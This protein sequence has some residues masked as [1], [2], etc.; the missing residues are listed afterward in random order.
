MRGFKSFGLNTSLA[1]EPGISIIVGPNG[2]GKSNIVDAVS[3]VLGEQSP[4]SLRG[5]SMQD[6]IFKSK[7]EEFAIA[8]VSLL[9]N[10]EDKTLPIE[11]SEVKLTRRAYLKGGSE[12]FINSSPARLTDIQDL[13][14][15]G[16]LGKGLYT[17]VNQGQINDIVL[18][19]PLERK[20]II[21][22]VIGISRHKIR[23]DKSKD[24]LN[25]VEQDINRIN[26]LLHEIKI[27]MDPLEVEAK[28]SK[29]LERILNELKNEEISLFIASINKLNNQ[30]DEENIKIER[31]NIEIKQINENIN[32]L[33]NQKDEFEKKIN[34]KNSLVFSIEENLNKF[35]SMVNELISF[36]SIV[37]NQKTSMETI[38]NMIKFSLSNLEMDRINILTNGNEE[39]KNIK[40]KSRNDFIKDEN[41]RNVVKEKIE[42]CLKNIDFIILNLDK[43]LVPVFAVEAKS[44]MKN[45]KLNII[46]IGDSISNFYNNIGNKKDKSSSD[47]LIATKKSLK[48]KSKKLERIKEI[49]SSVLK[50]VST[51]EMVL[52]KLIGESTS[53]KEK[54][55]IKLKEEKDKY[56]EE[57]N[58]LEKYFAELNKLN[59]RK[60]FLENDIY[61]GNLK[62]DQIKEKVKDLTIKIFDDYN[63]PLDFIIKNFKP[64][65]DINKT[66]LKVKELKN[67]LKKYKNVNPNAY[68]EYE[69]IK[70]RFDFLNGQ[71]ID[72]VDSK[73]ELEEIIEEL[74]K[75][76]KEH[77]NQKFQE[78]NEN[79]KFYFKILFP[80]GE[81][82]LVIKD[83]ENSLEDDFGVDIKVDIGNNKSVSLHLLS[84]GEKT[85]VSIAFLFSIFSSNP[86]PFYVFDEIDASLDDANIDRLLN[87]IKIFSQ[88]RQL[89]MVTHQKR[90]MEIADVI[91]GFSMQSNGITKIV[92]QKIKGNVCSN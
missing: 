66:E 78:I 17:I 28:K 50:N 52:S 2:S 15:E 6:V 87:L 11:F 68:L 9:F 41:F 55:N 32:T 16:G 36:K 18:F 39:N 63:M 72:L 31:N 37:N 22:E 69:R 24:R 43:W 73:K 86:S 49:I 62:K 74:D 61:R 77:F 21:D 58:L 42:Q 75:K 88:G 51:L 1:F 90:T 60:N 30:W 70:E 84:G 76:I 44:L 35:S 4:K 46:E 91:Y 12:Y 19:K 48:D 40:E 29:E 3:W 59:S 5:S 8:E 65:A 89:L 13:I 54:I 38:L 92:S 57:Q 81:G 85:L 64:C 45:V 27:T 53:I 23:R 67:E 10:N 71:K 79:F 47:N 34:N 83:Y 80:N 26:D 20:Q 14:S 56:G 33:T 82:E 7:G 25:S